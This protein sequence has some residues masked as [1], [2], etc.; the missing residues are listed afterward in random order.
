MVPFGGKANMNCRSARGCDL[1]ACYISIPPHQ[2]PHPYFQ[3]YY[4]N[5]TTP[6]ELVLNIAIGYKLLRNRHGLYSLE[7]SPAFVWHPLV[8]SST[9]CGESLT[10]KSCK[11]LYAS[12]N[13]GE[14][15][16]KQHMYISN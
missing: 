4:M 12:L 6:P 2:P 15:Y 8:V 5:V 1:Y 7:Y 13:C 16:I 11:I 14:M 10:L 3:H 9:K